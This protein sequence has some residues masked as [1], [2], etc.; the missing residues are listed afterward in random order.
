MAAYEAD[1]AFGEK[2]Y[3]QAVAAQ[4][5]ERWEPMPDQ[6]GL[7][8]NTRTGEIKKTGLDEAGGGPKLSDVNS[9]TG[10]ITGMTSYENMANAEPMWASMQDAFGRN[11]SQSDLNMV[12][13]MAKLFDPGSV[14][15]TEEGE[16]VRQ[17]GGLPTQ[18][19][20]L[21]KMLKGDP[22]SRLGDDVKKGMMQ[23][24]YSRMEGYN[25]A[26]RR[27]RDYFLDY[28]KRHGFAEGDIPDFADVKP[29]E[30]PEPQPDPNN[31]DQP[32][33]DTAQP[34]TTPGDL[35]YPEMPD[36]WPYPGPGYP[37]AGWWSSATAAEQREA[38]ADIQ[39]ILA[40]GAAQPPAAGAR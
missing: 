12:I 4:N 18:L 21:F 19:E 35:P 24:A 32:Q 9:F 26:W 5:A 17:T 33:P 40:G 39:R 31:P 6:P 34:D 23:E 25:Q 14:V 15:R 10:R 16:M 1:P 7:Q 2:L 8:R 11:T 37:D 22:T 29:F 36:N 20:G 30:A 28:A 38:L 13:A 3:A 27:D